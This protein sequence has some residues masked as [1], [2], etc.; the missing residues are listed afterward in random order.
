MPDL[1][2]PIL[3]L[4]YI[5]AAQAQKHVT[6]NEALAQL[7]LLVQ[8]SVI[9][10]DA[11]SAPGSPAEG[12]VYT[13]GAGA[14]GD[15]AGQDAGTIAA[16]QEGAWVFEAPKSGWIAGEGGASTVRVWDGTVWAPVGGGFPSSVGTLGINA[17]ADTTNRLSVNA[18]ATL[19]NHDG[20]GHQL[21]L[22]KVAP[23]DTASLLFQTGFSGRAEMGTAGSDDFF[24][25]VSADG[26]VWNEAISVDAPSGDVTMLSLKVDG[27][28]RLGEFTV[29]TLPPAPVA[30]AGAMVYVS[31]EAGGA[32][33]AFSDGSA[34]RRT[35]DRAIV[36]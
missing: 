21:K 2:S 33:T 24:V 4:P 32:V 20:A 31:D 10:F 36:S 17:T 22:N 7:D 29:A 12:D 11:T 30:G 27:P 6:H 5:A 28:T 25:K 9:A 34:W 18:E 13:I 19:L 23:V 16:F 35:T 15:F 26:V 8:L 1:K 3:S 14:T